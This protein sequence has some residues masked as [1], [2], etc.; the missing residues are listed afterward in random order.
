MK[1]RSLLLLSISF[2]S[3]VTAPHCTG[4]KQRGS[5]S[6]WNSRGNLSPFVQTALE[7]LESKRNWFCHNPFLRGLA[8]G[9]LPLS[10]F[11]DYQQQDSLYLSH[12]LHMLTYVREQDVKKE[13]QQLI[14]RLIS[15]TQQEEGRVTHAQ[16]AIPTGTSVL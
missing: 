11:E 13:H 2:F 3:L 8:Q 12:F 15:D 7:Y 9:T 14:D 16:V 1:P 5:S 10:A 6:A 4:W